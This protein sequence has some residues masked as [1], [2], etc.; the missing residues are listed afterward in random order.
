MLRRGALQAVRGAGQ[1]AAITPGVGSKRAL[2][3]S[4]PALAKILC[5]DSIDPVRTGKGGS[6]RRVADGGMDGRQGRAR[7][8]RRRRPPAANNNNNTWPGGVP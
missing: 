3:G 1:A 8:H 2:H 5:S 4:S 6:G 7:R